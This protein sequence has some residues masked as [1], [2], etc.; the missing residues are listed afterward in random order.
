MIYSDL[1]FS[2]LSNRTIT[3]TGAAGVYTM[4]GQELHLPVRLAVAFSVG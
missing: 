2:D 3:K 1:I 4:H